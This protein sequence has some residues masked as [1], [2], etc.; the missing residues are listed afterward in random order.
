MQLSKYISDLLYRYECVMV[1]NFG[2]FV[3]NTIA[4]QID[5]K[6]H[7]FTPPTK[8]ISFNINLQQNDGLL[9]NHIAKSLSISFD[10]AATRTQETVTIWKEDLQKAPLLLDNIGQ[11]T[12]EDGQLSFEPIQKTNYLTSS[13]G[14]TSMDA[15]YILRNSIHTSE[16]KIVP[17][18]NYTKYM[19]AAAIFAGLFIGGNTY[20]NKL[21][22]QQEIANQ[23]E[24]TSQ[25]QQASF[26]ILT[27]LPSVTLKIEK[28]EVK[29]TEVIHKYHIVAGA[30]KEPKNAIKKVNLLN[31]KGY[32]SSIMG[33]N[34]WGLTQVSYASFNN[35]NKAINTLNKIKR[36]DNKH[37]WLYVKE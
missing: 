19:V 16:D 9:I 20:I 36:T 37:A 30:F 12:S 17:K 33:V 24:I 31:K 2:G 28:E 6:N 5:H 11:L 23:Q 13:F 3:S 22:D 25:I 1:P 7:Q 27:P 10:E 18:K 21:V 35:K 15:T 32:K 34:K 29:I 14:L 8:N 4:T 26:T